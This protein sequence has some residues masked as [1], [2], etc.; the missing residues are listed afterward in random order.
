LG[1]RRYAAPG[2]P[3]FRYRFIPELIKSIFHGIEA[4]HHLQAVVESAFGTGDATRH[5]NPLRWPDF[6]ASRPHFGKTRSSAY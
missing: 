2:F 3:W 4:S 6:N 5:S 1:A